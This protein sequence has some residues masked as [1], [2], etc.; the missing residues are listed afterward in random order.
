MLRWRSV[1]IFPVLIVLAVETI[2]HR[3]DEREGGAGAVSCFERN[4]GTDDKL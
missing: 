4:N 3:V 1:S 2:G